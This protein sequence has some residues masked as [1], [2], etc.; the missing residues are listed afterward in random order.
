MP[1]KDSKPRS[2]V[3]K[4]ITPLIFVAVIVVVAMTYFR[5]GGAAGPTLTDANVDGPVPEF[6]ATSLDGAI[7]HFPGDYRGKVVLVD[8]WATWCGPCVAEVPHLVDVYKQF[9]DKGLEIIGVSLDHSQGVMDSS[10]RAFAE[11]NEMTWDIVY[12]GAGP[13]ANKWG[14][15]GIPA[16]FL[17]DGETGKLLAVGEQLRGSA[18]EPT[19]ERAISDLP[20]Q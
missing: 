11:K 4:I 1:E 16:P 18:L 10:V 7:V 12:V 8:F 13:I 19:V 5:G 6:Q 17:V 14:V 9:H 15:T 20:G 3:D 2:A